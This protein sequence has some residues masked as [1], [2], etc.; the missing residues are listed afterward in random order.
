MLIF[1]LST[2]DLQCFIT[3]LV[4][5]QSGDKFCDYWPTN[6]G[7]STEVSLKFYVQLELQFSSKLELLASPYFLIIFPYLWC[8]HSS[9]HL[10]TL[11][12]DRVRFHYGHPDIFDRI[13][14]ITR[15]GISKASKVINLTGD[16]FSGNF[17]FTRR[18]LSS[19]YHMLTNFLYVFRFQFSS[20]WGIYNTSWVYPSRQG[21][22]C[23]NESNITF[24]G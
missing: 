8:Y 1:L 13:F 17:S 24:R 19:K 6:F 23:W 15:G 5:V 11:Y 21:T 18:S 16:I 4:H 14:H 12:L 2:S 10:M 7:K 22:W 3:R 9:I 20:A